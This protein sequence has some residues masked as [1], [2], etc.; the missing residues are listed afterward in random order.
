MHVRAR[1]HRET[2]AHHDLS[3]MVE[4]TAKT[5]KDTG[6]GTDT[7]TEV[8]GIGMGAGVVAR[9]D[10]AMGQLILHLDSETAGMANREVG[11]GREM[12]GTT[13]RDDAPVPSMQ[14]T[15][16]PRLV[17]QLRGD[18]KKTCIQIVVTGIGH[19]MGTAEEVQTTWIGIF[20]FLIPSV[21]RD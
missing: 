9:K 15:G 5:G 12:G 16:A 17:L 4:A 10:R 14:T 1:V 13:K 8:T 20:Y 18:S 11:T 7:D 2:E 3:E 19:H 21:S 6:L